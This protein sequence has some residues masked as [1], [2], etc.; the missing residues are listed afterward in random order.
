MKKKYGL[1]VNWTHFPLH[2]ETPDAGLSL[3]ELF[4]GPGY[5]I[6]VMKQRMSGLMADEKLP[7]GN[8]SHTYNSRL[9]QELSKW[10]ES[11]PEGEEL[12]LKLFEAYFVDGYNL[13][14]PE[15]LLNVTQAASL[16]RE[17]AEGVIRE[18]LF[19]DA[20]NADWQR[21]HEFGVTGV[22][23]FVSGRHG[24]VGAQPYEALE[25]LIQVE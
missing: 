7:Y 12:N 17:V 9:A 23:T 10:G 21:A 3:D 19:Q 4:K 25:R 5:D 18:R 24:L 6:E 13:A 2:P 11:F 20:V 16:S 22:P 14:D 15:V 8:R 1:T